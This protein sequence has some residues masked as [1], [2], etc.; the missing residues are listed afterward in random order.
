MVKE[1]TQ[2]AINT[3]KRYFQIWSSATKYLLNMSLSLQTIFKV[4]AHLIEITSTIK[5]T[6]AT[7]YMNMGV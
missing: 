3:N 4:D 1:N 6:W 7:S 2:K 5:F